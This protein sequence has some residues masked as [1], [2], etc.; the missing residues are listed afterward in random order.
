MWSTIA[1]ILS[2]GRET[3][4]LFGG[5]PTFTGW[6]TTV[7]YF[8]AASL[9][10][11]VV[12][13]RVQVSP[14]SSPSAPSGFW[15]A[16]AVGLTGLGVNKQLDLQTWF[17]AVGRCVA[18]QGGWFD[19]RR[20]IEYWFLI[21]TALAGLAALLLLARWFRRSRIHEWAAFAGVACL[22]AFVLIREGSFYH[23][24]PFTVGGLLGASPESVLELAGIIL[25]SISAIGV[26]HSLQ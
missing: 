19:D 8:L 7:A 25:V 5:D 1:E 17:T 14:R 16:L 26:L 20:A 9:A 13:R 23:V 12:I 10:G 11:A 15:L 24:E 6:I 3:S 2:C 4:I 22:I 18:Q 21:L